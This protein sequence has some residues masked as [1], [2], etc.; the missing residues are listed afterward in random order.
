MKRAAISFLSLILA[1]SLAGL[2]MAEDKDIDRAD[3]IK[4]AQEGLATLDYYKGD[5]SGKMSPETREAVKAFKKKEMD[6]KMATGVLD[7]KTCDMISKK[8]DEKKAKDK[9]G[10][11][12]AVDKAKEKVDEGK[13]KVE[14]EAG[15]LKTGLD[16]PKSTI[17]QCRGQAFGPAIFMCALCAC[18]L[19]AC[20][21]AIQPALMSAAPEAHAPLFPA[22]QAAVQ[23]IP[24]VIVPAE[25]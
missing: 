22:G 21:H 19:P 18:N 15:K 5:A 1:L 11:K 14:G 25:I 16:M 8:A 3:R 10:G 24:P 2:C 23:I 13:S 6:M 7:E 4:Q 12:S 20:R 17:S 9:E